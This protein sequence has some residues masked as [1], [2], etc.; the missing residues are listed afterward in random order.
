MKYHP[1]LG[2]PEDRI[3]HRINQMGHEQKT[4]EAA[5]AERLRWNPLS[6]WQIKAVSAKIVTRNLSGSL[7][8][9]HATKY[10]LEDCWRN[11][12]LFEK[13][14]NVYGGYDTINGHVGSDFNTEAE[15]IVFAKK[16]NKETHLQHKNAINEL[17][18]E[19]VNDAMEKAYNQLHN[20][21]NTVENLKTYIKHSNTLEGDNG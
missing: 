9:R 20:L 19:E 7:V 16:V 17:Y 4:R 1:D 21:R 6:R 3:H 18:I 15:A 13:V 2:D 11:N 14:Y 10:H 12:P 8:H 5:E